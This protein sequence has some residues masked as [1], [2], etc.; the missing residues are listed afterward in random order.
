[1]GTKTA[2]GVGLYIALAAMLFR[3]FLPEGWMPAPPSSAV[4]AGW[5]PFVICTSDGLV[6]LHETPGSTSRDGDPAHRYAPCPYA[7]AASLAV[8]EA[9]VDVALY[10]AVFVSAPLF[11]GERVFAERVLLERQRSRAPPF[12]N[13]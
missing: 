4:D 11:A 12:L 6:R 9:G 2:S 5:A 7:A 1:M 10:D 3:A 8:P 13:I